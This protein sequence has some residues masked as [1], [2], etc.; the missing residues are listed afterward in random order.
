MQKLTN[1]DSPL[2]GGFPE[3]SRVSSGADRSRRGLRIALLGQFGVGN[4]GNEGSLEAM[5]DF[6]RRSRPDAEITCICVDPSAVEREHHIAGI[7]IGGHAPEGKLFGLVNKALLKVPGR[8]LNWVEGLRQMRRF[9]LLIVPGTGILDDFSTGPFGVPYALARWCASARLCGVR[10]AFVS[11]G[12]GPI[13]HRLSRWLMTRATSLAAYRS[14]RDELSRRFMMSIGFDVAGDEVFPDLAFGLDAPPPQ[15][16]LSQSD[17]S[18]TVGVGIM[19]YYGWSMDPAQGQA[20]YDAYMA[21][22]TS[23]VSWL[24][25]QGHRVRLLIG[26]T[27]DQSAVDDLRS[28]IGAIGE[29]ELLARLTFEPATSLHDIMRQ[30]AGTDVVIAT[31]YHNVVCALKVGRPT[32]S[33]SYARKNDEVLAS[34][35]LAGFHQNVEEFS[36][37]L[38]KAQFD[39]LA[40]DR[41]RYESVIGAA[42]GAAR[43]RLAEQEKN[44][45]DML[46]ARNP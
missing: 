34:M 21:K 45:Q 8:L 33:L 5:L 3:A 36:V 17:G 6:L 42:Y 38:L 11:I 39:A 40:A 43:S 2:E 15:A 30:M 27:V 19:S 14:Y 22:I 28:R 13:V 20:I 35:G 26:E 18:L 37:D 46:L 12:A 29:G 24:L 31:R 44:L 1:M 32:I 16:R 4:F 9:D 10:I 41:L 23:F 25:E 7:P